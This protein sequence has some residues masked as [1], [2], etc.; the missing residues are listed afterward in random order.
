MAQLLRDTGSAIKGGGAKIIG[1]QI[2]RNPTTGTLEAFTGTDCLGASAGTWH[3][4]GSIETFDIPRADDGTH[5]LT[6]SMVEWDTARRN[7]LINAAPFVA[8]DQKPEELDLEDGTVLES[9]SSGEDTTLPYFEIIYRGA[10][11][12]A[13]NE[14][15]FFCA[16]QL[17]RAGGPSTTKSGSFTKPKVSFVTVDASI[18]GTSSGTDYECTKPAASGPDSWVDGISAPTL[19]GANAHG[20]WV[21]AS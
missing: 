9:S 18:T 6:P 10:P 3:E 19:A 13:G 21:E 17:K 20:I 14:C 4:F 16:G 11:T 15:A 12:K 7:L 5:T 2:Q 1:K 8:T